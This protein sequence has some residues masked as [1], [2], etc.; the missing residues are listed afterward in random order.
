MFGRTQILFVGAALFGVTMMMLIYYITVSP[1]MFYA[2]CACLVGFVVT[3]IMALNPV[4]SSMFLA[5]I[6]GSIKLSE[7][8]KLIP[9]K[10][11]L[12]TKFGDFWYATAY[13]AV[14]V[15]RPFTSTQA[16]IENLQ[17]IVRLTMNMIDALGSLQRPIEFKLVFAPV[18][19]AR[20]KLEE[21]FEVTALDKHT[22]I[23][24]GLF[25]NPWRKAKA[26][27]RYELLKELLRRIHRG[28]QVYDCI[29]IV[30]VTERGGTPR[31]AISRAENLADKV[32]GIIVGAIPNSRAERI[33]GEEF[34]RLVLFDYGYSPQD[35]SEYRE[36]FQT[37]LAKQ[38]RPP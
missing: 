22:P 4:L 9:E 18:P 14:H 16:D 8:R 31:E 38:A 26:E 19:K 37:L 1:Y 27:V 21:Y 15:I 30:R 28:E 6:F 11:I 36:D 10:G 29:R 20:Q 2:F 7:N 32:A 33:V 17:N 34:V 35:L 23:T 3:L 5:S 25:A 24:G 12:L 13:V